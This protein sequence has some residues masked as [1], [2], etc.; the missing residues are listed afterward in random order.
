MRARLKTEPVSIIFKLGLPPR[1]FFPVVAHAAAALK[2]DSVQRISCSTYTKYKNL[3]NRGGQTTQYIDQQW[4]K[5][6][7]ALIKKLGV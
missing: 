2:A 6:K 7:I 1:K 5:G 3:I 4:I